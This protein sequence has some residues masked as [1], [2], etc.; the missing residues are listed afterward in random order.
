[1]KLNQIQN[2]A[3]TKDAKAFGSAV[4]LR[5]ESA[6]EAFAPAQTFAPAAMMMSASANA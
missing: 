1:M 4:A 6:Q 5:I 2:F 3:A